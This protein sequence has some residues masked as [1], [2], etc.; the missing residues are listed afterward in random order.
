VDLFRR[1]LAVGES[2]LFVLVVTEDVLISVASAFVIGRQP[3]ATSYP[4]PDSTQQFT[5]P[6]Q[7]YR[8]QPEKEERDSDVVQSFPEKDY[9]EHKNEKDGNPACYRRQPVRQCP[10]LERHPGPP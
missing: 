1:P 3:S 8:A 4:L 2:A 6:D 9:R 7:S 10:L 5:H